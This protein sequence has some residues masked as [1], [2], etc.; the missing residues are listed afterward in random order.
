MYVGISKYYN[1]IQIEVRIE[2]SKHVT[3]FVGEMTSKTTKIT[4]LSSSTKTRLS[5]KWSVFTRDVT[6]ISSTNICQRFQTQ[7][8]SILKPIPTEDKYLSLIVIIVTMYL[9]FEIFYLVP[10]VHKHRLV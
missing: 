6:M 2:Y 4:W 9:Q 3:F 5:T 1:P 8:S 10:M 7:N